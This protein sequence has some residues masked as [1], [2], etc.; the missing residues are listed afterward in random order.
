MTHVT[1]YRT[2]FLAGSGELLAGAGGRPSFRKRKAV[3]R[4]PAVVAATSISVRRLLDTAFGLN[5]VLGIKILELIF[6]K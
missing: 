4:P 3:I 2:S 6:Q 5:P 1:N